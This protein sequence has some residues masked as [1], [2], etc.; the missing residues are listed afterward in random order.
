MNLIALVFWCLAVVFVVADVPVTLAIRSA[1]RAV[2]QGTPDPRMASAAFLI[3][4]WSETRSALLA[5][6]ESAGLGV[7]IELVDQ[8]RWNA[9]PLDRQVARRPI[10]SAIKRL[11]M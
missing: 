6:G 2:L 4:A 5:G 8:I 3:N 10:W 1:V 9:L 7:L 11:R